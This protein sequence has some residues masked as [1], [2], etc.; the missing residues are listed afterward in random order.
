[1]S[2]RKMPLGVSIITILMYIG[3]ILDIAAGVFFLI[4]T[5]DVADAAGVE[6]STITAAAI[7]LIV[8]GV[9]VGLLAMGLRHGSNGVRI[10]I[11]VVMVLRIAGS[12]YII[13]ALPT[14][15]FEGFV[16]GLVAIVILYF[17]YGSEGTKAFFEGAS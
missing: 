13:F 11:A 16:S 7:G 4:E 5:A 6:N 2:D 14:A 15:R 17:L 10:L 9:I 8:V 3:A 1:M 12:I